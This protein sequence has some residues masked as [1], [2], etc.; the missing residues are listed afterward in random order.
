MEPVPILTQSLHLVY[1]FLQGICRVA[2]PPT[3]EL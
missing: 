2:F 1:I 3:V